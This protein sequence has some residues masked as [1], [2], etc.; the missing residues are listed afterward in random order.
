LI[1]KHHFFFKITVCIAVIFF[2]NCHTTDLAESE[3]VF[4]VADVGQGLSQIGVQNDT[5][6]VWDLGTMEMSG[7]FKTLYRKL[8][9]P[10][11]KYIVISHSDLDHCGG[12]GGIDSSIRWSGIVIVKPFE[13]TSYLRKLCRNPAVISFEVL[14]AGKQLQCFGDVAIECLWPDSTVES[15]DRN[16]SSF[17]FLL[18]HGRNSC[19]ITSDID[20]VA[21]RKIVT[22]NRSVKTDILVVP[23]HG[24]RNF[25]TLFFQYANPEHAVVSCARNNTFGHPS[26]E[27]LKTLISLNAKIYYTFMDGYLFFRSNYYYWVLY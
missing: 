16:V 21:Q 9:S 24:S 2:F 1:V 14:S 7:N 17:V 25:S 5:A 10:F 8:G 12:L 22:G 27:V 3:F 15:D 18:T 19:L 13:D 6:I 11:I 23:H 4:A 26:Q 20:S